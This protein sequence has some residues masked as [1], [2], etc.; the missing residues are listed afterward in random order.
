MDETTT[1]PL[2]PSAESHENKNTDE[3]KTKSKESIE[4]ETSV[5]TEFKN[6]E[7]Y[8]NI[9][10]DDIKTNNSSTKWYPILVNI[11]SFLKSSMK[12]TR[13]EGSCID[14]QSISN[15]VSP[16]DPYKENR[17]DNNLNNKNIIPGI[18]I[19]MA[20]DDTQVEISNPLDQNT[21]QKGFYSNSDEDKSVDYYIPMP[22]KQ[23]NTLLST[24]QSQSNNLLSTKQSQSNNTDVLIKETKINEKHIQP[25]SSNN[26]IKPSFKEIYDGK[27][28]EKEFYKK[29]IT[30]FPTMETKNTS[31]IPH[32]GDIHMIDHINKIFY[33]FELKQKTS[34]T[35]SDVVKFKNDVKNYEYEDYK[36]IGIFISSKAPIPIHGLVNVNLDENNIMVYLAEDYVCFN[37]LELL[38]QYLKIL[39]PVLNHDSYKEKIVITEFSLEIQEIFEELLKEYKTINDDNIVY[40]NMIKNNTENINSINFLLWK[41]KRKT[42]TISKIISYFNFDV[43]SISDIKHN[44]YEH[45][46]KFINENAS[47]TKKDLKMLFPEHKEFINN[48]K[49]D[50]LCS[51]AKDYFKNK[52]Q[53]DKDNTDN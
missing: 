44:S 32:N 23:N 41:N 53:N 1:Q 30:K 22:N 7:T 17:K 19:T 31:H 13:Y 9:I 52:I 33:I 16:E 36:I 37:I 47:V 4:C 24:K 6:I 42:I 20:E 5:Y 38:I 3:S 49:K 25:I 45:L 12:S 14:L 28:F 21:K 43:N 34:I 39:N 50:I 11:S 40:E 8:L 10:K 35:K 15:F 27:E 46:Y 29:L 2:D 48:N 51:K 18:T 26:F